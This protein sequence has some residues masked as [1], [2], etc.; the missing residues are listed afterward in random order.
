MYKLYTDLNNGSNLVFYQNT[1]TP[2][3]WL[4][5]SKGQHKISANEFYDNLIELASAIGDD[6]FTDEIASLIS[7]LQL[8]N[9]Q[10]LEISGPNCNV[11][12]E[13][14]IEEVKAYEYDKIFGEA[15][16]RTE[17]YATSESKEYFKEHRKSY[18]A[19]Y[20]NVTNIL[21]GINVAIFIFNYVIG[22][23]PIQYI[24]GGSLLNIQT[25]ISMLFAGFTHLS[26]LHIFFNM[27]FL[28]SIGPSLEYLLG[29]N[30]FLALYF[31]S[32]FFSGTL[33]AVFSNNPTAGASGALYG[34]FA[35]FVCLTLKHETDKQQV[36]NVLSTF[37]INIVF[38]L[39][40]PGISVF[41]HLGGAIAGVI[42][43]AIF[44]KK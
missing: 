32:L 34:L 10:T 11:N 30:R 9:P 29:R 36:R 3:L 5:A 21:V 26:I 31:F 33:V 13:V 23:F 4:L 42:A 2:N 38:T 20:R 6:L 25:W 27:S 8:Q 7:N 16:N 39:L 18:R 19:Q 44:N 28:M 14:L 1:N 17:F 41:G 15:I 22:Y 40:M 37:T 35:F 12:H 24:A 43:F